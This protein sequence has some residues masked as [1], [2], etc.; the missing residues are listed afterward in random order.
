MSITY[1]AH[2]LLITLI[3]Y[4]H[5]LTAYSYLIYTCVH[6]HIHF[7]KMFEDFYLEKI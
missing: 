4:I 1:Y 7:C 6:T 2:T 5:I 3:T